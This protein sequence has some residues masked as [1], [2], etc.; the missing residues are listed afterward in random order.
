MKNTSE[1]DSAAVGNFWRFWAL[2][3]SVFWITLSV[4][5]FGLTY[6]LCE[7]GDVPQSN[8]L[9]L[10]VAIATLLIIACVWQGVGFIMAHVTIQ[11]KTRS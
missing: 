11:A 3:L 5:I 6:V 9:L 2:R 8:R 10:F 4:L 1:H 7:R